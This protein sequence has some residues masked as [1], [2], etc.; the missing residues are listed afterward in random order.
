MVMTKIGYTRVSSTDGS[1]TTDRQDLGDIKVFE[2]KAS[3]KDMERP[4]LQEMLAYIRKGDEVIC[5]SIDRLARNLRDLEDIIKEVNSKG[6]SVTFITERLTFSGSDDAMSTLMLQ[7]MRAFS[8]FER[9][10]IKKRQAEGI[11]AAKARPDSPYKGRKPSIDRKVILQMLESGHSI[12]GI[13]RTTNISRQSVY[14]IKRDASAMGALV[15]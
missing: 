6:G 12:A 4:A 11:A 10:M 15:E 5:H 13:S 7:M 9:S 1:Q 14:R 8:Q 2:D 3:G